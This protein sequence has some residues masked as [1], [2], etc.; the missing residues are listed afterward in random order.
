MI[1]GDDNDGSNTLTVP[2][3]LQWNLD[4]LPKED[5]RFVHKISNLGQ[6]HLF[7][8]WDPPGVN[9]ER[10]FAFINQLRKFDET[11]VGGLE[12]YIKRARKL[13]KTAKDGDSPFEGFV[14]EVPHGVMLQPFAADYQRYETLG[15]SSLGA[16]GFVLVAGGLGERLG[17][18]GIKLELPVDTIT[19]ISYLEHYCSQLL[20][21][22]H[23]YAQPG[24]LIP[25][26]IMVSGDT[27]D[28]TLAL[29]ERS[30]YFGLNRS[31][32]T[33][34]CQG[35]VP[36]LMSN[37][38]RL[39]LSSQDVYLVEAKPHGHGDV[40]ALMH[41]SGLARR[42]LE[43]GVRY[44]VFFQDT[45]ALA[46]LTLPAML[47][48]SAE[49]DL[50]MNSLAIPRVAKQAIGAIVRLVR[51]QWAE[52]A[53]G[54][55]E[56]TV[57][58]EYNQL[59]PLLRA[60]GSV[61]GD[62]NAGTSGHSPFPGN[63]N[64]LLLRMD[65]YVEALERS[66]GLMPEFVNPKYKDATRTLFKKPTR[67]E[68]MMQDLP[69]VLSAQQK[70]GFTMAP[71]WLCFSP[72]KNNSA[73]AAIATAAG[74]PA[75]SP[76]T[77]ECDQYAVYCK[78]LRLLGAQIEEGPAVSILG[79]RAVPSPRLLLHPS[80]AIFPHELLRRFPSASQLKMSARSSLLL[81]GDVAVERLALDGA[82]ELIAAVE[83][84][85]QVT[86]KLAAEKMVTNA[87]HRLELLEGAAL[88][89]APE[90]DRIRGYRIVADEVKSLAFNSSGVVQHL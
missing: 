80:C 77:G 4:I 25:L 18:N 89:Q 38:A 61:E 65:S 81:R 55:R 36:A 73:D 24:Q 82:L 90:I 60:T 42:W 69:R 17:Y 19:G 3:L 35:E 83:E 87:G 56:L 10:K 67:L 37:D 27:H 86:V 22:Q 14:P 54:P 63:I 28:K 29:L 15:L 88:S 51:Q 8:S 9:N 32:L 20:A 59:D 21:I 16:C 30:N 72:V 12:G 79:I 1:V 47:G 39:A 75:A 2:Q 52:A 85:G 66:A 7:A 71:Q 34:L 5:Q 45:N 43:Q 49:L 31:Q 53:D 70:V 76:Y 62:V 40:H 78:L 58:V 44:A 26:A 74:V 84:Q 57:N 41:R 11:I 6:Q 68:C 33:L 48:V 64:Q 46:F 50:A 23:R 13:L